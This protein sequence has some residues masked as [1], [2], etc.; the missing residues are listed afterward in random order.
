MDL[1]QLSRA[2]GLIGV[3][4][5]L[6][7]LS[8]PILISSYVCSVPARVDSSRRLLRQHPAFHPK[9]ILVTGAGTVSGL[10][11]S[12]ALYEASHNVIGADFQPDQTST[13]SRFSR[14]FQKFYSLQLPNKD[15]GAWL[16]IQDLLQV[17]QKEKVNLWINC[18]NRVSPLEDAQARKVLDEKTDCVCIA[19]DSAFASQL[20]SRTGFLAFTKNLG[21]PT[22]ELH[23]VWSRADIHNILNRSKGN[24]KFKLNT[25]QS[26]S[27]MLPRRT[28]S[29]TYQE[30]SSVK[31]PKDAPLVLE[32]HF[33]GVNRYAIFAVVIRGELRAFVASPVTD[34][35]T[36]YQAISTTTG[37]GRAMLQFLQAFAHGLAKTSQLIS[38]SSF[39]C[40]R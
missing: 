8:L 31:I 26:K 33:D 36:W 38:R 23:P 16:Y 21:L 18:S 27:V 28:L 29:Q 19:L 24:K 5:F 40:K 7:P 30:V 39:K 25:T 3:S 9:T 1:S 37:V 14:A 15:Y 20:S 6:F 34:S 17:V 10:N 11:I 35:S 2:C 22:P 32:Q 13:H 12:R 4:L